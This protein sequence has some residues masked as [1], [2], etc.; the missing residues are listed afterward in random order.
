MHVQDEPIHTTPFLPIE[1]DNE[2][3]RE[4]V[5]QGLV[6]ISPLSALNAHN[7]RQSYSQAVFPWFN[8]GEPVL[9]WSP[10]PR[11]VLPVADFRIRR[12]FKKVLKSFWAE[13]DARISMDEDFAGVMRHCAQ[14]VRQGQRGGTWIQPCMME[15]Y[16]DLHRLG[17]AHSVEVWRRGQLVGGLY[18]V[19]IGRAVFGESM[20]SIESFASQIGLAA[21]VAFCKHQG[22]ELIDCQQNTAHLGQ[23]G[24][25][26]IGRE[27]FAAHV[28]RASAQNPVV[29]AFEPAHWQ[30]LA[31]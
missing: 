4:L 17:Q 6:G 11:M 20:F 15:A 2:A 24:A 21:L 16:T 13:A 18:A 12:S 19:S 10:D 1:P 8:E 7:L 3:L 22:I 14:A 27:A 29:W 26:A 30:A 31:L 28:L 25:H 9:W 5:A 23:L